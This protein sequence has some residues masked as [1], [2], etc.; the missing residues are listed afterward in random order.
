VKIRVEQKDLRPGS[1]RVWLDDLEITSR[2]MEFGIEWS[3]DSV[4]V[5]SLQIAPDE[6]EIDSETAVR[7]LAIVEENNRTGRG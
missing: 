5:A 1:L 4:T 2:L 3:R 6:L 7:L